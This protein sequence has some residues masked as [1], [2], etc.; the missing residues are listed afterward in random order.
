MDSEIMIKALIFISILTTLTVEGIKKLLNE[1]KKKYSAN[2]LAVIVSLL[3]TIICAILYIIYFSVPVT[4][5]VIVTIICFVY[6]SFL[7]AT[8]G[9]D[10]VKQ[11]FEQISR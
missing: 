7:V 3:L 6:L 2:I 1:K 4:A 10:K 11:V 5:Q 9:Y 8:V